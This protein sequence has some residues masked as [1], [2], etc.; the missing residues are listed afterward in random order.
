MTPPEFSRPERIDTIGS[1]ARVITVTANGD[2]RTALARRFGL[3]AIDLLNG[4]FSVWRDGNVIVAQGQVEARVTQACI[5]T[6]DPVP[7]R[8]AEAVTL[9]FVPDAE[10]DAVPDDEIEL[11]A[12]DCD[13]L[14]YNGGAIDL[15]EATAE[16]MVLALN[17]YPRGANAEAALRDAGVKSEED[18]R[19]LGALAS[20]RDK[21][22][23]G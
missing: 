7:A 14:Y 6:D 10:V 11:A 20:L 23:G 19:P 15:G 4:Q 8:I 18:A 13:T 5:V 16:T 3:I 2:E 1:G 17:P 22:A 9:R 21:L 12:E